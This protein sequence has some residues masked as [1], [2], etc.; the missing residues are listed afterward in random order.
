M[1]VKMTQ[2][3]LLSQKV[4]NDVRIH[5]QRKGN[6][7]GRGN[8]RNV[9]KPVTLA[10]RYYTDGADEIAFL[11][12][13]S[14]RS[15][16]IE[17]M[18]MLQILEAASRSIFVPLTVGGGIKSY[19]DELSGK[20]WS[21]L[22]VASQYFRA[23]ADK[24]SIGSD[25]VYSAEKFVIDNRVSDGTSSIESISKKYGRQAVVIS[26]DPKRIYVQNIDSSN[27]RRVIVD[28]STYGP[29]GPNGEM[30]CW[31]QCTVKGGR[32]PRDI[33]AV[34]LA[35]ICEELGAGEIM[36]NCIDMDGQCN[37]YDISL[38]K[39]VK[40]SVKIP[41]IASSGAGLERHFTDVFLKTDVHAA[42]AAGIF[43][44]EEV[45]IMAVKAHMKKS[46]IPCRKC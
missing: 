32:E 27:S 25:A 10:G 29:L 39:A 46:G 12:I 18:P 7:I 41:V 33:C 13:T 19:R 23:G 16:V 36:L 35:N 24:V 28:L 14:Y 6:L 2:V 17:D 31:Y 5:K 38:I 44:R 34:T 42:L 3:I 40:N 11:N 22:E 45:Q 1:Y 37:G 26:I 4:I 30:Y 20:T 9:G 15:G 8:V 21:A 43:H